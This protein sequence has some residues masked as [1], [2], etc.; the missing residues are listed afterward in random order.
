MRNVILIGAVVGISVAVPMAYEKNPA[1]F[2]GLMSSQPAPPAEIRVAPRAAPAPATE[3]ALSGRKVRVEADPTGHFRTEIKLNGRRIEGMIDTGASLV[4]I[5]S[6]TARRIGLLVP[7]S[8]FKHE[9]ST[10]NGKTRAALVKLDAIEIGRIRV[11]NVDA[12]VLDDR[13][14]STTLIGMSL[15][16]QLD[17]FE[18]KDGTLLLAQ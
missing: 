6:S 12:V 3:V 1:L 14:L 16:R 4:A 5:N 11:E 7:A 9:V 8:E 18:V 13:A 15:L 10:A 17:T 2:E